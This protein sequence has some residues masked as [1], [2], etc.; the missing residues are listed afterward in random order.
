[1]KFTWKNLMIFLLSLTI[2]FLI[3]LGINWAF[4]SDLVL[5]R[6]NFLASDILAYF[7]VLMGST[8]GLGGIACTILYENEK[9]RNERDEKVREEKKRELNERRDYLISQTA[10]FYMR[11]SLLKFTEIFDDGLDSW[12]ENPSV[13]HSLLEYKRPLLVLEALFNG[14][15]KE[16]L[17]E[18][19]ESIKTYADS[20]D[21]LLTR[22]YHCFVSIKEIDKSIESSRNLIVQFE[23]VIEISYKKRFM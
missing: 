7:S 14:I 21:I 23:R 1:M 22:L 20:M 12:K 5:F 6:T 18:E 16:L 8:I 15:E 2:I 9:R 10:D 3:P 11:G 17:K 4:V 13:F 19:V